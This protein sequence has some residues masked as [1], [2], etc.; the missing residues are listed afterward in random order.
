M[1]FHATPT[2]L[3]NIIQRAEAEVID[4]SEILMSSLW[5]ELKGGVQNLVGRKL[6]KPG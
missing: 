1:M 4:L 2:F 3:G 5:A 6:P